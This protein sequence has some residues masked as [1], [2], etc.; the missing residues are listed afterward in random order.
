MIITIYGISGHGCG[1]TTGMEP[2]ARL[3][4]AYILQG[5]IDY[6]YNAG[7]TEE[8]VVHDIAERVVGSGYKIVVLIERCVFRPRDRQ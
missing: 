7:T 1:S 5:L 4:N 8:V 6:C 2:E 3:S